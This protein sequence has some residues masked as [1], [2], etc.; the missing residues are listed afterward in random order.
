M[1]LDETLKEFVCAIGDDKHFAVERPVTLLCSHAVCF[2]CMEDFKINSNYCSDNKLKC[3]LCNKENKIDFE[4]ITESI[5]VKHFIT[6]NCNQLF[7]AV[8]DK[9]EE[10]LKNLKSMKIF[11]GLGCFIIIFFFEIDSL[12]EM[13]ESV[14]SQV[15]YFKDEIE[16]KIESLKNE[17]EGLRLLLV[18]QLDN[19]KNDFSEYTEKIDTQKYEDCLKRATEIVNNKK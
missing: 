16:V 6:L 11:M 3:G 19:F 7:K 9:Y 8:K 4:V 5:F 17:L 1:N 15:E 18:N 12:M 13:N 10:S 2:S 14:K